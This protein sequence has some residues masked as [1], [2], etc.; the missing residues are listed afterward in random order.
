MDF[1]KNKKG[2]QMSFAWI[3]AIIVG[4]VILF[5]AIFFAMSL[6]RTGNYE[7]NT[8]TAQDLSSLLDPLQTGSEE[9][10]SDLVSLTVETRIYTSCN[11]RGYFG[12]NRIR[13]SEE[14]S[15]LQQE[16]SDIGGDIPATQNQYV[17]AEDMIQTK[18]KELYFFIMPFEMP[19]KVADVMVWHTQKYCFVNP[20]ENVE[21]LIDNLQN[22][23]ESNLEVSDSGSSCSRESVS[24]CFG[25]SSGCDVSVSDSCNGVNCEAYDEGIVRKNGND[26]YYVGNLM[27]AAIFSSEDNYLCG[28]KRLISRVEHLSEVYGE[29]AKFVKSKGCGTGLVSDVNS[30]VSLA[31]NYN[32]LRE[33][34][35]IKSKAEDIDIKNRVAVCRLY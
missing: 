13:V 17:F 27:Y 4:A 29:K 11:S 16:W 30:L 15:F 10:K 25:A 19:Y 8:K 35:V 26:V 18:D 21:S 33:L 5:L 2:F 9:A 14:T 24:V 12:E 32:D 6:L 23:E 7:I 20:P 34:G 1:L 28:V 31:R 22:R 3:F